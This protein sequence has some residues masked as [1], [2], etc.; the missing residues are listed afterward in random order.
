MNRAVILTVA[1]LAVC[2]VALWMRRPSPPIDVLIDHIP[3]CAQGVTHIDLG[4]ILTN[5]ERGVCT[6]RNV[7]NRGD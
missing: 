7:R 3:Y 1:I 5:V 2:L 6:S 4:I